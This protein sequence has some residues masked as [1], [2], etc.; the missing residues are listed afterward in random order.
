MRVSTVN[1]ACQASLASI[2]VFHFPDL[3]IGI[4]MSS[5]FETDLIYK[6]STR[7]NI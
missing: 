2:C 4:H 6:A 1:R 3:L 7:R 5:E